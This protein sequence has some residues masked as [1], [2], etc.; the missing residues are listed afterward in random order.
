VRS[1]N[2]DELNP[3][4]LK[5]KVIMH[6]QNP[7]RGSSAKAEKARAL[8]ESDFE[9]EVYDALLAEGYGVTPQVAVGGYRIDM[10]IEGGGDRRLAVELDGEKWHSPES[11]GRTTGDN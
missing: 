7:M 6:F 3:E 1:L 11:G 8:C 5:A 4:D 2:L 9:R 10:V